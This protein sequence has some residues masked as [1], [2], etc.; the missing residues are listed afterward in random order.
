MF[1][2]QVMAAGPLDPSANEKGAFCQVTV[3]ANEDP[4]LVSG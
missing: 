1:Q 3:S 2:C 4:C